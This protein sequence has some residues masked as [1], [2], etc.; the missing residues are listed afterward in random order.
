MGH[1][2]SGVTLPTSYIFDLKL[3]E[4]P[5]MLRMS[6]LSKF[7]NKYRLHLENPL[8]ILF[9]VGEFFNEGVNN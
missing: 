5:I 9:W 7:P 8:R 6:L 3:K 4:K 2:K 1:N